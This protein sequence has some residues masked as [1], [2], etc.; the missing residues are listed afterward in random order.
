LEDTRG[1][2]C[3]TLE[4]PNNSESIQVRLRRRRRKWSMTRSW[5]RRGWEDNGDRIGELS[6]IGGE[7]E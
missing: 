3:G 5:W 6:E 4:Q 1:T 2:D 7:E